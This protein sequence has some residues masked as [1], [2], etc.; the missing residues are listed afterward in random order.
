MAPGEIVC[1]VF[2]VQEQT[3]FVVFILIVILFGSEMIPKWYE[4]ANSRVKVAR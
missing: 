2:L 1:D 3:R 4:S